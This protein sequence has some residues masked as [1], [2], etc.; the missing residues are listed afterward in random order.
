MAKNTEH[1]LLILSNLP[2]N[3]GVYQMKDSE[4]GVMYVG[5]AKNLKNRVSSYFVKT[6]ELS[7]AKKQMVGKIEDIEIITC[8][9]EVEALVLETNLIKHLTPKYNILMKD[10]K[11]LAYLKITNSPVPE[12]IKTRQKI[13]DG[14]IYFGPYVSAVEQ[15]VR[16]LRRIFKIRNCRVKFA[17]R[18]SIS[19][20]HVE[21]TDK[22]GKT[23]PCMDY[24]IGICPAPCL[25]H[26]EKISIHNE[27]LDRLKMFLSGESGTIFTDLENEM[28]QKASEYEFEEAQKIKETIAALRGLHE[29]QS[30]RDFVDG[31]LDICIQYEKYEKSYIA[32]TQVR[33]GQVVGVF[34][35]EVKPG[36]DEGEDIMVAFLMR[37]YL[38]QEDIPVTLLLS[39]EISDNAFGDFIKSLSIEV[40]LP[41][42]G[43]KKELLEFTR[44][45]LREY[46]YKKELATL[47]NKTLTRDHMVNVLERIGYVVPQKGEIV[48]ECYD[49][50][51]TDG[52]FTYASRVVIVNG[53]PDTSRYKKYKIKTLEDGMIDD[54]AS[55]REVM[56][57]R[58]L[59]GIREKNFPHLIIIDGG[60]G[61][62]SSALSGIREG[63]YMASQEPEITE[64]PL[65][66]DIPLCSI[67]KREEEIFIPSTK[68]PI[69]FE[70]GTP[71]LM[72]LQKARDESHRFSITA[73]RSARTKAMKKNILEELPGI[74]PVTRKKLL[75][76]AGSVDGIKDISTEELSNICTVSQIETLRDHG[77]IV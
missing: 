52:H 54:F 36:I 7:V 46:A 10:D 41:K 3:P 56:V 11:N 60:K 6:S 74:G 24:Y 55:H 48:F 19:E 28:R 25:L 69:L 18:K 47:E 75:K 4:G 39:S 44:N 68:D 9:T 50:S 15:S 2:K 30:V 14:A 33:S 58:T 31:D 43:P 8:K 70:H 22:A 27:N 20:N 21:I 26:S 42:I 66:T 77:I 23:L 12:I 62:L 17:T 1:I 73:N 51:H 53:K 37:Q 13:R 49:I 63:I 59:E 5:K 76:L 34:R 67:A 57:R 32:L 40:E 16:A 64:I 29:R 72:V 45:Q 38:D 61:Q 35:H 65:D 71:E